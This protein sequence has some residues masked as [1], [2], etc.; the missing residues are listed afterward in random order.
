MNNIEPVIE[1]FG[2]ITALARALGHKYPTTVQG[3]KKRG[4]IPE[5]QRASVLKAA[6]ANGIE[7]KSSD[8]DGSLEPSQLDQQ[9][10]GSQIRAVRKA[11]HMTLSNLAK[12]TNKS[13]GF[14][15][16]IERDAVMPSLT[17][18]QDICEAL[19]IGIGWFFNEQPISSDSIEHQYIVRRNKRKK[20][21]FINN[22]AGTENL[23]Y[24][25]YLLS[26]NLRG[27]LM[28]GITEM[29]PHSD[30]GEPYALSSDMNCYLLEGQLKLTVG[31]EEFD[32]QP[33]DSYALTAGT[34]H[35]L[36]NL[37]DRTAKLHWAVSPVRIHL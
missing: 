3:W 8:L 24:S 31:E 5:K 10:I 17:T 14:L 1:M 6:K 4:K 20:L 25:D 12:T 13:I 35:K 22:L 34:I 9:T 32:I 2:G 11:A 28:T 21:S 29:M 23:G 26:P 36:E 16:Q 18:L 33:G 15:S 27:K 19:G 37:T 7:L 30:L